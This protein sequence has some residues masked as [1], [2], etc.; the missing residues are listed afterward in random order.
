[1]AYRFGLDE[2]AESGLR[3]IAG[4]QVSKALKQLRNDQGEAKTIHES[5][6]ALKR[7][8]A[9]L[10]LVHSGLGKATFKVEY[11]TARDV[12]RSLS[13]LRDLEV[14]PATIA[15]LRA[16]SN[17]K[18]SEAEASILAAI[19]RAQGEADE[20]M[21][22]GEMLSEAVDTLTQ[23]QPRLAALT[24]RTDSFDTLAKGAASSLRRLRNEHDTAV[25][26]S[27][28]ELYHEWRKSAQLHWRHL[29]LLSEAWPDLVS[30]RI[31][32]VRALAGVL[33]LDHD[34]AVLSEFVDNM[35]K[36]RLSQSCRHAVTQS[37]LTRQL[38]LR[39][40]ARAY[41]RLLFADKP[42]RF[43]A[44]LTTYHNARRQISELTDPLCN[45]KAAARRNLTN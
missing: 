36:S 22:R 8:K 30:A 18:V 6:K 16:T 27:D 37:A 4:E 40:E 41:A 5:R 25:A 42:K 20:Q 39:A 17:P 43:A 3:R 33:G 1:L 44:K 38:A 23:A 13:I 28:A 2:S 24:L 7:L 12:G 15:A 35:P 31:R 19:D 9:L 29:K 45:L 11:G 26:S 10:N 32:V 14:M 34:L 21:H